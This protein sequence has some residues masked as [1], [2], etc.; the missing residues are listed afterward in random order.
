[1]GGGAEHHNE[2]WSQENI[3]LRAKFRS[4]HWHLKHLISHLFTEA[5]F[6]KIPTLVIKNWQTLLLVDNEGRE[7]S[8]ATVNLL[9]MPLHLYISRPALRLALAFQNPNLWITIPWA[10]L[11]YDLPT[12]KARNMY[13]GHY[14]KL[15]RTEETMKGPWYRNIFR[16]IPLK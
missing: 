16:S 7:S 14:N 6:V 8:S 5:L 11:K 9:T 1:M 2:T 10:H 15:F 3:T 13:I 4:Y 12:C